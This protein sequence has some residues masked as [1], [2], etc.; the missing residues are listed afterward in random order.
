V[1]R[2]QSRIQDPASHLPSTSSIDSAVLCSTN[3]RDVRFLRFL[4]GRRFWSPLCTFSK[5]NPPL[6]SD[7]RAHILHQLRRFV[8]IQVVAHSAAKEN[9]C[10]LSTGWLFVGGV[11]SARRL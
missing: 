2:A 11:F 3:T 5:A 10:G 9:R 8:P 4:L 6:F 1:C 7:R